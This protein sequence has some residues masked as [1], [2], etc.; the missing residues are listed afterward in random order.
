MTRLVVQIP[1]VKESSIDFL[2][3]LWESDLLSLSEI[4]HFDF[5]LS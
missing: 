3:S 1:I 5:D 2:L 4:M